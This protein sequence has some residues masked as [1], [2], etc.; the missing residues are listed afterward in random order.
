MLPLNTTPA[1]FPSK[2]QA[3]SSSNN[4][5][6]SSNSIDFCYTYIIPIICLIGILTNATDIIVF[7]SRN[8]KDITFK[9]LRINAL[10]NLIYLLISFF[11]FSARCGIYCS[12][13]KTYAAQIYMYF[14]YSYIKGI[15]ALLSNCILIF[16]GVRHYLIVTNKSL[17]F[18]NYYRLII[19]FLFVFSSL[20]NSPSLF[21]R[22]IVKRELNQTISNITSMVHAYSTAPSVIGQTELGKWLII[23]V[24]TIFRG[25]ITLF[26]L[27]LIDFLTIVKLRKHEKISR[28][29]KGFFSLEFYFY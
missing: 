11:L 16:I 5:L 13:S 2:N 8:L 10:A 17:S 3:S 25:Y 6:T 26:T 27:I 20:L 4:N 7:S 22:E 19:A 21:T 15:F 9:Y 14:F 1:Y 18:F 29:I 23:A 28:R 12:F 24:S